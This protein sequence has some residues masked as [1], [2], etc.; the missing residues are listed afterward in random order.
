MIIKVFENN[1]LRATVISHRKLN[2]KYLYLL[3]KQNYVINCKTIN[4]KQYIK[5]SQENTLT[6]KE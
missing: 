1:V 2:L 3:I 5:M 6:N 4:T